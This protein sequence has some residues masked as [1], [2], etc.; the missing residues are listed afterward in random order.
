MMHFLLDARL[1]IRLTI[2]KIIKRRVIGGSPRIAILIFAPVGFH[3]LYLKIS[4]KLL[5]LVHFLLLFFRSFFV[6]LF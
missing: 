3:A 5:S 4:E 2:L 6:L 1:L